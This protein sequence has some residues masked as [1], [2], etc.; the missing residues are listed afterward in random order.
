MLET[1]TKEQDYVTSP[2]TL[3]SM[4][5][6]RTLHFG[7][8]SETIKTLRPSK[9]MTKDFTCI[10]RMGHHT[11]Q[12]QPCVCYGSKP[13]HCP[14]SCAEAHLNLSSSDTRHHAPV[15][16]RCNVNFSA[17]LASQQPAQK[18]RLVCSQKADWQNSSS[19]SICATCSMGGMSAL[20]QCDVKRLGSSRVHSPQQ[21][22]RACT[23]AILL[24]HCFKANRGAHAR[25]LASAYGVETLTLIACLQSAS[26]L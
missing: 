18:A 24:G 16:G 5:H 11:Q 12:D 21:C 25:L 17:C 9:R 10:P 14:R 23:A 8:S 15:A 20:P 26:E 22:T 6:C 19:S 13:A 1:P 3:N 7:Q 4:Q 2:Y